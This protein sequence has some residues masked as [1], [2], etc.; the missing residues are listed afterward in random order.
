MTDVDWLVG[1]V[2]VGDQGTLDRG[3]DL[4]VPPDPS[5]QGEQ[6]LSDPD[7][8]ALGG[9]SAVAFQ[10]KL[11]LEG[12]EDRLHPLAHPTQR[13]EP[14]RLI[15]A[16]RACQ[17]RTQ[18][19]D[20]PFELAPSQPLVGQDDQPGAQ[21]L[22]SGGPVQQHLGDRTFPWVGLARHQATGMPSG[23]TSRYSLRPQ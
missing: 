16:V 3:I 22:L 17:D 19:A 13:P 20:D 12:V 9:V 23:Q 5:G 2:I 21:H 15:K 4:P 7:P 14:I 8:H 11:V 1:S 6:P 10:A 18:V